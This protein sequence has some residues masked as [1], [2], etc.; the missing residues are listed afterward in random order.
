MAIA[1]LGYGKIGR[2]I[3]KD[4]ENSMPSE[5]IAVFDPYAKETGKGGT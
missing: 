1:V 3:V 2:A 5:E 4:L